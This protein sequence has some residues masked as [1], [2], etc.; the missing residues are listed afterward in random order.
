LYRWI[1]QIPTGNYNNCDLLSVAFILGSAVNDIFLLHYFLGKFVSMLN[2]ESIHKFM[3]Q[4]RSNG[5]RLRVL[6]LKKYNSPV[7]C[8]WRN[9]VIGESSFF[10]AR[11]LSGRRIY[12]VDPTLSPIIIALFSCY[13]PRILPP[14]IIENDKDEYDAICA[15]LHVQC[16]RSGGMR[17]DSQSSIADFS[18]ISRIMF[19]LIYPEFM[20][21]DVNAFDLKSDVNCDDK[22]SLLSF[23]GPRITC[24][25]LET[26]FYGSESYDD[27]RVLL[28]TLLSECDLSRLREIE[29]RFGAKLYDVSESYA[30]RSD[31]FYNETEKLMLDSGHVYSDET[32]KERVSLTPGRLENP[33]DHIRGKMVI[34]KEKM[35]EI[36]KDQSVEIMLGAKFDLKVGSYPLRSWY[37]HKISEYE[38]ELAPWLPVVLGNRVDYIGKDAE[39]REIMAVVGD[40]TPESFLDVHV[41][42]IHIESGILVGDKSKDVYGELY[43]TGIGNW[44]VLGGRP[45]GEPAIDNFVK[46]FANMSR[47][48]SG[49]RFDYMCYNKPEIASE[50]LC[51]D[52]NGVWDRPCT[53]DHEC[54]Y[55]SPDARGGCLD[56]YCEMPIGV[57]NIAFTRGNGTPICSN[58]GTNHID[59]FSCCEN[60]GYP[61]Y[62]WYTI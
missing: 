13:N 61:K 30:R 17:P 31:K 50:N 4:F 53:R 1:S 46:K 62:E 59:P 15:R 45:N 44:A 52:A 3:I 38:I 11:E 5:H 39:D 34:H 21:S 19:R 8:I 27:K 6:G 16:Y 20:F 37:V 41:D 47:R 40:I 24:L 43:Q 32:A 29:V 51:E 28:N 18:G 48:D 42:N 22:T 25:S 33:R 36:S 54:P 49:G 12:L 26:I 55:F 7:L 2:Q 35:R 9:S 57:E 14:I 23:S 10:N 56:G 60:K 58:C